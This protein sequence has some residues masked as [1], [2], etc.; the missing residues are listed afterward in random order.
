[1]ALDILMVDDDPMVGDVTTDL[2]SEV[3]YT[4][5]DNVMSLP[6]RLPG[7]YRKLTT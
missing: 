6:E 1:M 4:I 7:I 3:G 5:I 2:L